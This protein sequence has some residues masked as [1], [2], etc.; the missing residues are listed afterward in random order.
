MRTKSNPT[1]ASLPKKAY[2]TPKVTVLGN[3][4][5]LTLKIGSGTDGMGSGSFGG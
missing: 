1:P 4:K 5:K 2:K 3:V